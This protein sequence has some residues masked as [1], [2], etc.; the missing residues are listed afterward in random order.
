M[1]RL[2]NRNRCLAVINMRDKRFEYYDSLGHKNLD[3]LWV[4]YVYDAVYSFVT[5]P[6]PIPPRRIQG[7]PPDHNGLFKLRCACLTPR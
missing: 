4:G 2:Y 3:C 6:V 7:T 1:S 5:E